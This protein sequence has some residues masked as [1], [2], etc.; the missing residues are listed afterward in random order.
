M[1]QRQIFSKP[2]PRFYV[3]MLGLFVLVLISAFS[4]VYL[5]FQNRQRYHEIEELRTKI[6]QT[7][8]D[9]AQLLRRYNARVNHQHLAKVG[10]KMGFHPPKP[11]QVILV[12]TDTQEV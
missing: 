5:Q 11:D 12:H 7:N 9:Y 6:L 2:N 3:L 8:N 4:L 10:K 1:K